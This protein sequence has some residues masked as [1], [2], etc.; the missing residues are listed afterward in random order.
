MIEKPILLDLPMPIRTPRLMITPTYPEFAEKL[1]DAKMESLDDLKKW[2]SWASNPGTLE[3]QNIHIREWYAKFILREELML[4]AFD[5][6]GEFVA[7]T[8][9]HRINWKVPRCEI[10]YWCRTS[11][12]GKGYITEMANAL[13]RYAFEIMKMRKVTI[14]VDSEN[15]KSAAVAKRLGFVHDYD[16]LGGIVIPNE[17]ELRTRSVYACYDPAI[18]PALEVN[19]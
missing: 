19:W 16:D 18:L 2:M 17:T 5:H 7:A 11:A 12:Q 9:L 1:F 14:D 4:L 3:E 10:G 6:D 13:T 15:A 8:G